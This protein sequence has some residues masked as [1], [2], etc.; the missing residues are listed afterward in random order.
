MTFGK[1]HDIWCR[2]VSGDKTLSE[3]EVKAA[4]SGFYVHEDRINNRNAT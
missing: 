4:Q 1:A 3:E 2:V